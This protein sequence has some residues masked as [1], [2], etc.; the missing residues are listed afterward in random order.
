M[1][2]VQSNGPAAFVE[3]PGNK[4][5][6]RRSAVLLI[7][8][9]CCGG[10]GREGGQCSLS[11]SSAICIWLIHDVICEWTMMLESG[12]TAYFMGEECVQSV[13]Y[14]QPQTQPKTHCQNNVWRQALIKTLIH[15]GFVSTVS[16]LL[17]LLL[18]LLILAPHLRYRSRL[19]PCK[20]T[21]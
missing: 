7:M 18:L 3:S 8:S 16:H 1:G 21:A 9:S 4:L 17:L 11:L 10:G 19:F 12:A 5:S 13:N 15:F 2:A 14:R 6:E 20:R